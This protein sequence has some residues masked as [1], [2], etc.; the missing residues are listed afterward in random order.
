M[1]FSLILHIISSILP[2]HVWY[3]DK[4]FRKT[5]IHILYSKFK[6]VRQLTVPSVEAWV[7]VYAVVLRV[8][9]TLTVAKTLA[10]GY[11]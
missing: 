4:N 6:P 2:S 8:T 9:V 5:I 11:L 1:I 10:H 7:A 3:S